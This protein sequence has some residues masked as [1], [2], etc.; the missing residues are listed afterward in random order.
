MLVSFAIY[1]KT[2]FIERCMSSTINNIYLMKIANNQR[3][4]NKIL[5][6]IDMSDSDYEICL[7]SFKRYFDNN[8]NYYVSK[9]SENGV[10]K[11]IVIAERVYNEFEGHLISIKRFYVEDDLIDIEYIKNELES[12]KSFF[13]RSGDI[14]SK[15]KVGFLN[16]SEKIVSI[17]RNIGFMYYASVLTG[18]V[19]ESINKLEK[20]F[21]R[22]SLQL[23]DFEFKEMDYNIDIDS[24][25]KL[26][27]KIHDLNRTSLV[28]FDSREKI[29]IMK[30]HFK[31]MVESESCWKL[32]YYNKVIGIIGF[33]KTDYCP[34][35]VAI[36][37]I[38]IEPEFQKRGLSKFLFYKI[39]KE[40]RKRG[41][42]TYVACTATSELIS[43]AKSIGLIDMKRVFYSPFDF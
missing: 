20:Y 5:F 34:G 14:E 31:C 18:N 23:D 6:G 39:V 30:E 35:G 10:V 15:I 22:Y 1:I 3:D 13:F 7:N 25:M 12:I 11:K 2:Q 16:Q 21:D 36:D 33:V 19:N 26:M 41:I 9:H 27:I 29:E 8:E 24:I 43:S 28:K 38:C 32:T 40:M 37:S 17:F 4:H 42:D